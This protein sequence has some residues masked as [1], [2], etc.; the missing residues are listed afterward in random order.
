MQ[1]LDELKQQALDAI[2]HFN[3][4]EAREVA[5]EIEYQIKKL[6]DFSGNNKEQIS[7]LSALL[8][9]LRLLILPLLK[10]DEMARLI[11]TRAIEMIQ[12]PDLVFE[13]RV[14]ARQLVFP[15]SLRFE[16]VNRPIM[17]AL[18]ENGEAISEGKILVTGVKTAELSMVKNWLLDYDRTYGTEPQKDLTWLDY[19][20]RNAIIAHLDS[21]QADTLRKLLRLYEWLKR[22]HEI[23]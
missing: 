13:E 6:S 21:G 22:E 15:K 5:Q 11:K 18:H 19:T 4:K 17:D 9:R 16:M 7:E 2:F 20:K 14:E 23:G 8:I 12:D 1:I 10:D 3:M